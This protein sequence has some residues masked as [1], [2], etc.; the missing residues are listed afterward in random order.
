MPLV[1]FF[2]SFSFYFFSPLSLSPSLSFTV[3]QFRQ[4]LRSTQRE[5]R[6]NHHHFLTLN[7][8]ALRLWFAAVL[9]PWPSHVQLS[10]SHTPLFRYHTPIWACCVRS[11]P[12]SFSLLPFAICNFLVERFSM[13]RLRDAIVKNVGKLWKRKKCVNFHC[14][15]K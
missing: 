9:I 15:L 6:H 12:P 3:P 7:W 8:F 1:C 13:W 14:N 4:Q 11:L 10:K 2:F 5:N